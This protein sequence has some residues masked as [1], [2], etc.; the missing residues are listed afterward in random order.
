[1]SEI[2]AIHFEPLLGS[3]EAAKLLGNL[4]PKTVEKWARQGKIP[5]YRVSRKWCFRASEL[6]GWLRSQVKSH[7]HLCRLQEKTD[8][9]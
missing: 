1:M 2:M 7:R 4:H 5:A 6:D 3:H 8:A 9:A